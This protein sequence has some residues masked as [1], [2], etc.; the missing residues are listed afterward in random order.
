M[1]RRT[2]FSRFS[3]ALAGAVLAAHLD[4]GSLVPEPPILLAFDLDARVQPIY[5]VYAAAFKGL[6]L[7]MEWTELRAEQ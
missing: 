6:R 5:D 2:F 1:N 3:K 7:P 4:F